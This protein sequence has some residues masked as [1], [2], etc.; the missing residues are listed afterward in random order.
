[1]SERDTFFKK[2]QFCSFLHESVRK[3]PVTQ[4]LWGIHSST[5]PSPF[6]PKIMWVEREESLSKRGKGGGGDL[7]KKSSSAHVGGEQYRG[8]KGERK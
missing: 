8:R 3:V 2:K 6:P 4:F 1:M 7:I 5:F